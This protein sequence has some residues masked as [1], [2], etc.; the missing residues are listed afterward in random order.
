MG[1]A[2]VMW[3]F[4]LLYLSLPLPADAESIVTRAEPSVI[5][6][7]LGFDGATVTVIGA[8]SQ[9]T[10]PDGAEVV[11]VLTG[12]PHSPVLAKIGRSWG[13]WTASPQ[14]RI[15][16]LP[17]F[18]AIATSSSATLEFLR[19]SRQP[20][21]ILLQDKLSYA[22]RQQ[23]PEDQFSALTSLMQSKGTY[24][25]LSGAVTVVN[26]TL[27]MAQ[28]GLPAGISPGALRVESFL[29]GGGKVIAADNTA[30]VAVAA[31]LPRRILNFLLENAALYATVLIAGTVLITWAISA[32]IARLSP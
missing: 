11:V 32:V 15:N 27:F 26:D 13:I 7:G 29:V 17:S 23:I 16:Y 19:H 18:Y 22:N 21:R 25:E 31:A 2:I 20:A 30:L 4:L 9:E 12:P 24:S 5:R 8:I 6:M 1:E 3:L 14:Q 28:F 10:Q